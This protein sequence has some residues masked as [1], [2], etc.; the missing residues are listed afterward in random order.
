MKADPVHQMR[1]LDLQE[2]DSALGRLA[3][4][5]RTI[6]EIAEVQRL[7]ARLSELQDQLAA[8]QTRLG[9]LDREQRKAESDVDQ[10][11]TR[12]ERDARRLEAGQ[13][14]SPRELEGLQSEIASL[15][16][17]QGELE[18]IVLDVMERREEAETRRAD[19]EKEQEAAAEERSAAEERRSTTAGEIKDEEAAAAERRTRVAEEIPAD[20]LAL[21]TRLRDQYSG[22]GAAALRYGRCEGC[23][24]AL[25]TA[26][27][28]EIRVAPSDEVLR[29]EDCRRILVRTTESGLQA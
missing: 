15:R 26:E 5:A 24:L 4:R 8:A 21:Y 16:R 2:L 13:V 11:R 28:S 29:C 27:L 18:E 3:H 25:S 19:L 14:S 7:D 9:D 22:V 6:P 12:A 1:L 10:V 23:K 20:L 17:R